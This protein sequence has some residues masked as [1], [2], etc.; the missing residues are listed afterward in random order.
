M[1]LYNVRVVT[2][3][4][5]K[6][7]LLSLSRIILIMDFSFIDNNPQN[8]AENDTDLVR[9][10]A[11]YQPYLPRASPGSYGVLQSIHVPRNAQENAFHTE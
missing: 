6:S 9:P 11:K 2:L 7:F 3:T 5:N 8:E 1:H 4:R 10:R